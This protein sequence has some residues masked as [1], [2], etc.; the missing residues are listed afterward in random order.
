MSNRERPLRNATC[1]PSMP[2][3]LHRSAPPDHWTMRT[4]EDCAPPVD[5][6]CGRP[7][8]AFRL[9]RLRSVSAPVT[10]CVYR[11]LVGSVPRPL[12][13]IPAKPEIARQTD[14][15][16]RPDGRS[17]VEITPWNST[18]RPEREL[19][20]SAPPLV[21]PK[22]RTLLSIRFRYAYGNRQRKVEL[23]VMQRVIV[24]D[25]R[26]TSFVSTNRV[27]AMNV[28]SRLPIPGSEVVDA[29]Q[30]LV[31]H[32]IASFEIRLLAGPVDRKLGHHGRYRRV[33]F[34]GLDLGAAMDVVVNGYCEIFHFHSFTES[35]WRVNVRSL[36]RRRGI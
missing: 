35:A 17:R 1:N 24:I 28:L 14:R 21:R 16:R 33:T 19:G 3:V 31:L 6:P 2:E 27:T 10:P 4:A 5:R 20:R 36:V 7:A 11:R 22:T 18:S 30:R 13:A 34:G 9:Q 29:V 32:A 8:C 12:P 25:N 15:S 26:E 23:Y